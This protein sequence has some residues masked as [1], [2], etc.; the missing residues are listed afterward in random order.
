LKDVLRRAI[1]WDVHGRTPDVATFLSELPYVV[2]AVDP[3]TLIRQ[4]LL[5]GFVELQPGEFIMGARPDE[6]EGE[7]EDNAGRHVRLTRRFEM[8]RT[9]VTQQL[10]LDVLG[11][12]PSQSIKF[13]P[14]CPVDS[15]SWFEATAFCNELSALSGLEP[16]YVNQESGGLIRWTMPETAWPSPGRG[17]SL[18]QDTDCQVKPSGSMPAEAVSL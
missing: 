14:Q 18:R 7:N 5:A 13:G 9:P 12:N 6:G 2:E 10:W 15:V 3:A 11:Y 1:C 17:A 16:A 4:Q 8:M